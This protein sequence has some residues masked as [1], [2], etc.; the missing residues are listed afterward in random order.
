MVNAVPGNTLHP[1]SQPVFPSCWFLS[2][3]LMPLDN[4]IDDYFDLRID[5]VNKAEQTDALAAR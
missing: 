2:T 5:R 3:V 1:L 4:V